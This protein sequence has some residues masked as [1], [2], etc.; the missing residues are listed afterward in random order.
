M[1]VAPRSGGKPATP[2]RGLVRSAIAGMGMGIPARHFPP[3]PWLGR[4]T[5]Y[6][7][8]GLV[9]AKTI[10]AMKRLL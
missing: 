5:R 6:N 3:V 1:Q 2:P 8:S 4:H 7:A 9:A 10:V